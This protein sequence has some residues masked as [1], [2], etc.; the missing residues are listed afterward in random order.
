MEESSGALKQKADETRKAL[1]NLFVTKVRD[2]IIDRRSSQ[3]AEG[4]ML[5]ELSEIDKKF[6]TVSAYLVVMCGLESNAI[7]G[8]AIWS[9]PEWQQSRCR[10]DVFC[11]VALEACGNSFEQAAERLIAEALKPLVFYATGQAKALPT[12]IEQIKTVTKQYVTTLR[13]ARLLTYLTTADKQFVAGV[14]SEDFKNKTQEFVD[15]YTTLIR[16]FLPDI[17][18][19]LEIS[20]DRTNGAVGT[21]SDQATDD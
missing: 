11:Y 9:S 3:P 2:Q 8:T 5:F 6:A 10:T 7:L 21:V 19:K 18:S 13:Y 20:N 15:N 16:E 1:N 12:T 17:F 14:I 4:V